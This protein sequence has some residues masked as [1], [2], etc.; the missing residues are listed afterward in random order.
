MK[1]RAILSEAAD[2][3]KNREVL[4][5]KMQ[6]KEITHAQKKVESF[7]KKF[8]PNGTAH[9]D[10]YFTNIEIF[11]YTNHL[12]ISKC[13]SYFK[14]CNH[15]CRKGTLQDIASDRQEYKICL[16]RFDE[17]VDVQ[18]IVKNQHIYWNYNLKMLIK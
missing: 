12:Q 1:A 10:L 9:A 18:N 7:E 14:F 3:I 2:L 16:D 15:V 13:M 11:K 6:E 17:A 4:R 8:G 5:M